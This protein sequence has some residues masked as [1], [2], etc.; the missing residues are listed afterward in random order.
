[1]CEITQNKYGQKYE[2]I[3]KDSLKEHLHTTEKKDQTSMEILDQILSKNNL[4]QAYPRVYR[5]KGAV[6]RMV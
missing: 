4:N 2:R 1:M 6:E 5:N 3:S